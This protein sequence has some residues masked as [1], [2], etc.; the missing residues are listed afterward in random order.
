MSISINR[1]SRITQNGDDLSDLFDM[2]ISDNLSEEQREEQAALRWQ[3]LQMAP[4][5]IDGYRLAWTSR[6]A[7]RCHG[8]SE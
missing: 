1:P 8:E 6:D 2:E 7:W 5:G 3:Q 4:V